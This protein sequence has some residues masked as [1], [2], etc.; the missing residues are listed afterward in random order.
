M[1]V[2]IVFKIKKDTMLNVKLNQLLI[3]VE[4]IKEDINILKKRMIKLKT[5]I[6]VLVCLFA[7]SGVNA[8]ELLKTTKTW[9]GGEIEYHKGKAEV[10]SEKITLKEGAMAPFHCHPVPT[11]AYIE[12]G[13][14]EVE[15]NKG[16]KATF[17]E[18]DSFVEALKTIHR[19]IAIDGP[20]EIVVFYAGVTSTPNMVLADSDEASKYCNK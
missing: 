20:V 18:G 19:G 1:Q 15:T 8:Q 5:L 16:K 13:H 6:F 4:E 11:L 17:Q 3:S 2:S 9:E 10:T 14:L 12:K 7:I